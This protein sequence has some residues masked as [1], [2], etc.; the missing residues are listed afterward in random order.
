ML[1]GVLR[2]EKGMTF[3]TRWVA[4]EDLPA[5]FGFSARRNQAEVRAGIAPDCPR[6]LAALE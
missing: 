1:G 4:E 5:S 3:L 6:A 2:T